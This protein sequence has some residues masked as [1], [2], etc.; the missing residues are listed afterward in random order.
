MD[1]GCSNGDASFQVLPI[2]PRQEKPIGLQCLPEGM[3]FEF[4]IDQL[5]NNQT[6]TNKSKQGVVA[7]ARV[8]HAPPA[9]DGLGK[10]FLKKLPGM[11]EGLAE[12]GFHFLDFLRGR[13]WRWRRRSFT[14]VQES[15]QILG[16]C[17]AFFRIFGEA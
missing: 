9:S 11:L 17:R 16:R 5:E 10:V 6:A 15:G 2:L 13:C 3:V 4:R 7:F 12:N 8:G 1:S 14:G